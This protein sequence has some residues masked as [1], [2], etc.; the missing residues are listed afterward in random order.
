MSP[1]ARLRR[2]LAA[3]DAAQ[4]GG[5][6]R[7]AEAIL[8]EI[9]RD[10][11][12]PR[13]RRPGRARAR[14]DRGP[15][16]LD[17]R[18]ELAAPASRPPPRGRRCHAP[19]PTLYIECVDPSIRAG[20]PQEAFDAA[21]RALELAPAGDPL[22]L[23][24]RI[25]RAA[26]LVFLGDTAA[27]ERDIDAV[28]EDVAH[29]PSV[30][31]DLQLRAYLGM[32]L[33]FAE[34]IEAASETLDELIDECEQSAPGRSPTRSSAAP[35]CGGQPARGRA[36]RPTASAAVRLA[37]QLGRAN[38]ECWGLSILTW[39]AAAQGRLDDEVLAHQLE[40]SERLE[41]PYQLMC[42]HACRGHHALAAGAADAAAE[43]LARA[44]AIKRECG[45]ADAT[46]HPV[47]GADLVE[48][49]VRCGRG[50]EAVGGRGARSHAEALR[51]GRVLGARRGGARRWPS[52]ATTLTAHFARASELH[53][54]AADP[55][56]AARTALGVGRRAA[57]RRAAGRVPGAPRGGPRRARAARRDAVGGAGRLGAR[58]KRQGAAAGGDPAR[59][60]DARRARGGEPRRRRAS[61][62]RRSPA[63]CG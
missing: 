42:V 61:A 31:D 59:R 10:G 36:R 26:S 20:R 25:A 35:G 5:Q 30:E 62:T 4:A 53:A 45:I 16:Q 13:R 12:A 28:A 14:A 3:A 60:A 29:T 43:Q 56:A 39:I 6:R 52:P 38:D 1:Q 63:R 15:E 19:P 37:R 33:A 51:S 9:E 54:G 17:A 23:L 46:T 41:L 7:A 24:A 47:I 57:P 22:G 32:T 11:P 58:P 55:F 27:A 44:L 50:D 48:A 40:L 2:L 34:R 49:L 8:G 21:V 18:R